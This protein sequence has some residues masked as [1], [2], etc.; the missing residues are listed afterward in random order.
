MLLFNPL[1]NAST[2]LIGTV[3]KTVIA[4]SVATWDANAT[5]DTTTGSL[6]V[7]VTGEA[8]KTIRWVAYVEMVEV[9]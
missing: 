2:I 4:E 5:A 6:K 9:Q 7:T 8:A 3:L 1:T